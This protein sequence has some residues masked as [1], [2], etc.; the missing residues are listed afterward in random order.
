MSHFL[1]KVLFMSLIIFAV[2]NIAARTVGTTQPMNPALAGFSEGCERKPQPCWYGIV[3]G[4]TTIEEGQQ[5][6]RSAGYVNVTGSVLPESCIEIH[7]VCV[8][9]G[10]DNQSVNQI[11]FYWNDRVRFGDMI[12][13]IGFPKFIRYFSY[14]ELYFENSAISLKSG[15]NSAYSM[16]DAFIV[17]GKAPEIIT[18]DGIDRLWHGFL[19]RWRYCQ[20]EPDY[21]GCRM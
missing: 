17:P 19:P 20:L 2:L 5:F 1:L 3:P 15:W 21:A 4:V 13:L 9:F 10:W 8:W 6:L 11:N 12:A 18:D 14:E 16:V 7:S